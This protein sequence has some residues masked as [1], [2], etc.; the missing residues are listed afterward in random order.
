M[1]KED[2]SHVFERRRKKL[3]EIIDSL[4]TQKALSEKTGIAESVISRMLYPAGKN[5]KRNIGE[6]AVRDIESGLGRPTGWFDGIVQDANYDDAHNINTYGVQHIKTISTK[7]YPLIGWGDVST[8]SDKMHEIE[9]RA[10]TWL[11][12]IKDYGERAFWLEVKDDTMAGSTGVNY[13][14]GSLILVEP[15]LNQHISSGDKVIARKIGGSESDLTFRFFYEDGGNRW[16]RAAMPGFPHLDG[17]EYDIVG[18]VVGA[19]LN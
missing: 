15:Y 18:I 7:K 16:L 5:G 1:Q 10:T 6:Q 8:W 3:Q 9:Q 2:K 14:K 11:P 17:D 19:W 4:G 13:P 12:S